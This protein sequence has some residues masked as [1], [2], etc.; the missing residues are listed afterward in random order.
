MTKTRHFHIRLAG[1]MNLKKFSIRDKMAKT[2]AKTLRFC[3]SVNKPL[4][5]AHHW[6]KV[7]N[8]NEIF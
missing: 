5:Y 6:L 8:N 2:N 3:H 7:K 1:F 4:S